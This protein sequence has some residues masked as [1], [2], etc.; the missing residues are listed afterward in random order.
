M[1]E[2]AMREVILAQLGALRADACVELVAC[3]DEYVG[4]YLTGKA[5]ALAVAMQM[6]ESKALIETM[7]SFLRE[8]TTRNMNMAES[9][10]LCAKDTMARL[11]EGAAAGYMA[12]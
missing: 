9:A 10:R 7:V 4:D 1:K 11:R 6:V 8:E 2:K 5:D 12:A 3:K